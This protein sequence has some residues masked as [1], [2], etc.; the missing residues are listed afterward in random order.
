MAI[1]RV[2]KN[3]NYTCISNYHLRD[4]NLSLKAKGLLSIMLSLPE[5]WDYS[6]KGLVA[7][8]QEE[9]TAVRN[10]LKELKEKKYLEINKIKQ[11]KENKG[12][13]GY[14]YNVYEK[15][16]ADKPYIENPYTD[17]DKQLNTNIPNTDLLNIN[18]N[19]ATNAKKDNGY[20]RF[21]KPT[22][23]EIKAYCLEKGY[24]IDAEYYYNYNE[25]RGWMLGRTHMKNWKANLA[26]WNSMRKKNNIPPAEPVKT[27]ADRDREYR[28]GMEKL[29]KEFEE[30]YGHPF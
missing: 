7:L 10:A 20:K 22:V 30:Q 1:F 21:Q 12:Y 16:K 3:R 29:K 4:K 5:D 14:E 11:T 8:V 27:S 2:E 26:T 25:A 23:E 13:I 28:E 24:A 18:I 17:C 15:P 6:F 19:N 9:S